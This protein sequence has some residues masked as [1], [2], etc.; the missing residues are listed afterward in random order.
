MDSPS[1]FSLSNG[2]RKTVLLSARFFILPD[3]QQ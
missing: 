1:F 3:L 2:S